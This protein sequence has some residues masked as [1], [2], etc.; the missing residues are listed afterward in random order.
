[1]LFK[2]MFANG[3]KR[4]LI[5]DSELWKVE[6]EVTTEVVLYHSIDSNNID[7]VDR[8]KSARFGYTVII[9]PFQLL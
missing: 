4:F 6:T 7:N 2:Q 9:W 8:Y 1:M 5:I 3:N